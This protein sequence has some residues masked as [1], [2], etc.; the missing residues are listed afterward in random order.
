MPGVLTEHGCLAKDSE[1]S[2]IIH[3]TVQPKSS[4]DK[5]IG[6]YNNSI[7]ISITAPPVDGKANKQIRVLLAKLLK[8]PKS[9]IL[10]KSG[11]QSR[12][13]KFLCQGVTVSKVEEI[14]STHIAN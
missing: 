5:I 4:R 11:Q 1:N 9:S 12:K 2:V 8:V 3:V 14:L 10:L 6:I 7:K 13:K